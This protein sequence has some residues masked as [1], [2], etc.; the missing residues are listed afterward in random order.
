MAAKVITEGETR[1]AVWMKLRAHY[2]LRLKTLRERNDITE[3]TE[4]ETAVLRGQIE[5]VKNF[6]ALERQARG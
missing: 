2:E 1:E 5:E 6:L 3:N 4:I